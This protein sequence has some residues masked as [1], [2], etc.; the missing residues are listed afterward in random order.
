ME[1]L[2]QHSAATATPNQSHN[3]SLSSKT[4]SPLQL[5]GTA[6]NEKTGGL[7]NGFA[8]DFDSGTGSIA[9]TSNA[10]SPGP[11]ERSSFLSVSQVKFIICIKVI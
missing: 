6:A 7:E 11:T 10:N 8:N 3:Q 9:S 1:Q 4:N 5:P 2:Q